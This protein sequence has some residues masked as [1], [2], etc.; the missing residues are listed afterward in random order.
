[1][2]AAR[3][4]NWVVLSD[5][6]PQQIGKVLHR[7]SSFE[8]KIPC[9][10]LWLAVLNVAVTDAME[11]PR[12]GRLSGTTVEARRFFAEPG[13]D[14][15]CDCVGL[16]PQYVRELLRDHAGPWVAGIARTRPGPGANGGR[17]YAAHGLRGRPGG[18]PVR[19]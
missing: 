13:L 14:A 1:V 6:T 15:I 9:V 5:A 2:N 4:P 8:H 7:S 11:E 3:Q 17:G 16:N 10:N 19:Q 12:R 18:E